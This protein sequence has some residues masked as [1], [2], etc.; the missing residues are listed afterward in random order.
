M[1]LVDLPQFKSK[2]P[3]A[4]YAAAEK[5]VE[6]DAQ[7]VRAA[8][9]QN[10]NQFNDA[11][12]Q[13]WESFQQQFPETTFRNQQEYDTFKN[14]YDPRQPK[15]AD[16][17]TAYGPTEAMKVLNR[18]GISAM[19]L[20]AD[21]D[22]V[23]EFD[24]NTA[25]WN[26]D[27]GGFD[28]FARVSDK[29]NKRSFTAP[30]LRFG[31]KV[32]DVFTG[33]GDEAVEQESLATLPLSAFENMYQGAK[34]ATSRYLG[35]PGI[36]LLQANPKAKE[37]EKLTF[38]DTSAPARGEREDWLFSLG[39]QLVTDLG[40]EQPTPTTEEPTTATT[41]TTPTPYQPNLELGLTSE[42]Y[43][44]LADT[45]A[46]FKL[47]E[48]KQ[49]ALES[50]IFVPGT[51]PFNMS[52]EEF[53]SEKYSQRDREK[54][55]PAAANIKTMQNI[56]RIIRETLDPIEGVREGFSGESVARA[57]GMPS[58]K[59][60]TAEE[61]ANV[62]EI[63]NIYSNDG[64]L[65]P[66]KVLREAFKI[67]PNA[68]LEFQSDPIAFANKYKNN[69]NALK[70]TPVS[71][72]Q[73]K[74]LIEGSPFKLNNKDLN[75]LNTAIKNNDLT[76]F[77]NI[78]NRLTKE[79]TVPE[80]QQQKIVDFLGR[81]NNFVR[82]GN[83]RNLNHAIVMDMWSSLTPT[84]RNTYAGS[85]IRFAETGYLTFEGVEQQRKLTSDALSAQQDTMELSGI[86]KDL[87][88]LIPT[89][90]DPNYQLNPRDAEQIAAFGQQI[91]NEKDYQALLSTSGIYLK[92]A[93]EE[94]GSP[95]LLQRVLSFG[96]AKGPAA[97]GFTL[98]PN[99]VALD[100]QNNYTDDPAAADKFR[101]RD[102]GGRGFRGGVITKNELLDLIGPEGIAMLMGVS[103]ENAKR[104]P[105]LKGGG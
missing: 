24:I 44:V 56:N 37:I 3:L 38:F 26:P 103:A 91:S 53:N 47:S 73:S 59:P 95:G 33:G 36:E 89:F 101:V 93:I 13:P 15:W 78:L 20:G 64:V 94:K 70:G 51:R 28:V 58:D 97:S 7:R 46:D 23:R 75:E 52:E 42:D 43:R 4:S 49:K 41:P 32:K 5:F 12:N 85:L 54:R 105:E 19:W 84:Q 63:S 6:G 40:G 80:A 82:T 18:T 9:G 35:D 77:T 11:L 99:V 55:L 67:N 29:K 98:G 14:Q 79:G 81:S 1:A 66:S 17:A 57:L 72:T 100:A 76:G 30:L 65:S 102:P 62:D 27:E 25:K 16:F 21:A 92:R 10:E 68:M 86:G 8:I 48:D 96:Q 34:Y 50:Y 60:R 2:N 88:G 22:E 31:K 74:E 90:T 45:Q 104:N 39:T 87:L 69:V 71:P 83:Q 61:Q